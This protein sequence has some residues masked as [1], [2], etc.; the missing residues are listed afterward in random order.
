MIS[1]SA[2][3]G[4]GFR[5]YTKAKRVELLGSFTG[6]ERDPIEMTD[7]GTGWF[8]ARVEIEPGEHE[9]QYRLDGCR[10]LADFA[11]N[12]VRLNEFGLW[13]SQLCVPEPSPRRLVVETRSVR[14]HAT[15]APGGRV[16]LPAA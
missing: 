10:W 11:A 1:Q 12:G 8:V 6:W 15:P 2:E 7:L 9:F 14:P 5:L 4:I 16:R 3:G 13:V